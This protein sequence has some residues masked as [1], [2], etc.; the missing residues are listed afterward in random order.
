MSPACVKIL[1]KILNLLLEFHPPNINEM[2]IQLFV[3]VKCYI[4]L[5]S[6]LHGWLWRHEHEGANVQTNFLLYVKW[7][8]SCNKSWRWKHELLLFPCIPRDQHC[9]ALITVKSVRGM[10]NNEREH[11]NTQLLSSVSLKTNTHKLFSLHFKVHSQSL[12]EL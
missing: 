12:C 6:L 8:V 5:W 4:S 2:F 11:A 9:P 3:S 10:Q 1:H 7:R